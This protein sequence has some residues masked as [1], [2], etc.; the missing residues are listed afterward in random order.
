MSEEKRAPRVNLDLVEHLD[1]RAALFE[2]NLVRGE[3]PRVQVLL[4]DLDGSE[5]EG[6]LTPDAAWL[7]HR[8]IATYDRRAIREL[9][10][11]LGEGATLINSEEP[12]S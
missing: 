8:I 10:V 11:L 12:Q 4:T 2:V 1:D 7:I 5:H 6:R 9:G 3:E